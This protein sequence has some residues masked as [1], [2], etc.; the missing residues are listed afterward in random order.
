MAKGKQGKS[1]VMRT[2]YVVSTKESRKSGKRSFAKG[3]KKPKKGS[4]GK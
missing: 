4:R 2:P 3:K 1:E